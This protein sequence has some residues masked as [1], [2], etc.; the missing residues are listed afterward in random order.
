MEL[1][2][3]PVK[4]HALSTGE[5]REKD[6]GSIEMYATDREGSWKGKLFLNSDDAAILR[7]H[8]KGVRRIN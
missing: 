2:I 6:D 4:I 8:F 5:I 1:S 3:G 7:K